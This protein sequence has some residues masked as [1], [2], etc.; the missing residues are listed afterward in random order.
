M[1]LR[2]S[3]QVAAS[4]FKDL[5]RNPEIP[6]VPKRCDAAERAVPAPCQSTREVGRDGLAQC[7]AAVDANQR[8][9]VGRT[10][11]RP[12]WTRGEAIDRWR[13]CPLVW[14]THPFNIHQVVLYV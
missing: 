10:H 9:L 3:L 14:V 1:T 6:Q 8:G 11:Q 5:Q 7:E 12:G 13:R 4:V 2:P